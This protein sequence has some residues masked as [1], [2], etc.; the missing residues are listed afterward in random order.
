[1]FKSDR[2][3]RPLLLGLVL[4]VVVRGAMSALSLLAIGPLFGPIDLLAGGVPAADYALSALLA[5]ATAIACDGL[6][7]DRLW[8]YRLGL[9]LA[10][11]YVTVNAV[12]AIVTGVLACWFPPLLVPFAVYVGSAAL[13]F[14]AARRLRAE[15]G[16]ALV[17]G[18]ARLRRF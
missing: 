2:P 12:T 11:L 7:R 3:G 4:S 18:L 8:A 17:L 5:L 13:A 10:R 15:G 9:T 6:R 16:S 1:M 14:V